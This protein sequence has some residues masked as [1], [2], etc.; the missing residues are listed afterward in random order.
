M[1]FVYLY[2]VGNRYLQFSIFVRNLSEKKSKN[3][4][5]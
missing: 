5:N 3:L 4:E 2:L 1:K